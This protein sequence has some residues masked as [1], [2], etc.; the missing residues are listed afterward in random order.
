MRIK[1]SDGIIN[2]ILF[3]IEC[4]ICLFSYLLT[5]SML[6]GNIVTFNA[7]L[8]HSIKKLLS[9]DVSINSFQSWGYLL[10]LVLIGASIV[11]NDVLYLKIR[12]TAIVAAVTF[13]L[14]F[15]PIYDSNN[16][17]FTQKILFATFPSLKRYLSLNDIEEINTS[18]IAFCIMILIANTVLMV[19]HTTEVWLLFKCVLFPVLLALFILMELLSSGIMAVLCYQAYR[20]IKAI[21]RICYNKINEFIRK[22]Q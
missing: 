10:S 22:L 18:S 16:M 20:S 14:V 8:C 9:G 1:I 6:V 5:K 7:I 15:Y 4:M 13:V 21:T 12:F 17:T 2:I 11:C 3:V 19:A